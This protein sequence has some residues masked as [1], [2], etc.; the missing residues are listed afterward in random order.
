MPYLF[1]EI[2]RADGQADL[3]KA[4]GEAFVRLPT[5][6]QA[7]GIGIRVTAIGTSVFL[8][9]DR[10]NGIIAQAAQANSVFGESQ[11]RSVLALLSY[12]MLKL[13][14]TPG[15]SLVEVLLARLASCILPT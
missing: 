3:G 5:F 6:A 14:V 11:P 2:D 7:A 13:A 4:Q 9:C 8:G 12:N 10:M 1:Q 15:Q